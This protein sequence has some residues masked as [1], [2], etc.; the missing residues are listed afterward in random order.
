MIRP[1][2]AAIVFC[3]LVVAN[4]EFDGFPFNDYTTAAIVPV[5]PGT[6]WP[7]PYMVYRNEPI[8]NG[9]A[10]LLNLAV[11][12]A[13]MAAAWR[14]ARHRR[15]SS[16]P[17]AV[18]V[19]VLAAGTVL[20]AFAM[21]HTRCDGFPFKCVERRVAVKDAASDDP[22]RRV[23]FLD[24]SGSTDRVDVWDDRVQGVNRLLGLALTVCAAAAGF[25][26]V[27]G[28]PPA[29]QPGLRRHTDPAS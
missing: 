24:N 2:A 26:I 10:W 28:D 3:L 20:S 17:A 19:A 6:H 18:L 16:D 7:T 23:V 21:A 4:A 27:A 1:P 25:R 5:A 8:R 14:A 29:R 13:L 11:G 22:F 12:A 9:W 15:D